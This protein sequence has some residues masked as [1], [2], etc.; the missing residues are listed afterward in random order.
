MTWLQ[1][2]LLVIIS[3]FVQYIIAYYKEKGKNLAQ[4]EDIGKITEEIK[5]VETRFINETEKLKTTLSMIANI[6]TDIASIERNSIIELNKNLF[7][8]LDLTMTGNIR[9]CTNNAFLDKYID[10]LNEAYQKASDSLILF[11]LFIDDFKLYE[12]T[13][14]LF[15]GIVNMETERYK[16]IIKLKVINEN[17]DS[18]KINKDINTQQKR[19]KLLNLSDSRKE[20]INKMY[21][22]QIKKYNDMSYLASSFQQN[23]RTYIYK[24]IEK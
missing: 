6:K 24:L 3:G 22:K 21:N 14:K 10:K 18:T 16:D 20:L 23:C 4:K 7:G 17:Y 11:R 19:K 12:Q 2:T 9:S 8:F 13:N 15:V 1:F 5:A